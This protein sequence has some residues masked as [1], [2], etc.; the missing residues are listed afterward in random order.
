MS[1]L[2]GAAPWIFHINRDTTSESSPLNY[3]TNSNRKYR[4]GG[5]PG[6]PITGA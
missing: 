3:P 5:S 6:R 1:S 4:P 2:P